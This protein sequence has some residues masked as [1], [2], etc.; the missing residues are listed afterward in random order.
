MFRVVTR[1]SVYSVRPCAT[2]FAVKRLASTFGQRVIADHFHITP[3]LTLSL[4]CPMV[5][6]VLCT[7]PVFAIIPGE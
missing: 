4:G 1:N 7:T 6:T 3:S 5:T 2:G